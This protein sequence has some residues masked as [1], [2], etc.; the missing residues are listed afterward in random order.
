MT[1][2]PGTWISC[3]RPFFCSD[4]SGVPG[5]R[6]RA[7]LALDHIRP[8]SR[9]VARYRGFQCEDPHVHGILGKC[10]SLS[11]PGC[12]AICGRRS[13][14]SAAPAFNVADGVINQPEAVERYAKLILRNA[15]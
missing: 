9:G 4:I 1:A 14:L 6:W 3:A 5:P 2:D 10:N 15:Q 8:A 12:R 7:S 13:P 11:Q